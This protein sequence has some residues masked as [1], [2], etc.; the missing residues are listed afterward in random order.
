M[1]D[2]GIN[3]NLIIVQGDGKLNDGNLT[4]GVGLSEPGETSLD[5][6]SQS[7]VGSVNE[8]NAKVG[9]GT[10]HGA[11]TFAQME[12]I[13]SPLVGD[14]CEVTDISW[15]RKIFE[16]TG[17]ANDEGWQVSGETKS[18]LCATDRGNVVANEVLTYYYTGAVSSVDDYKCNWANTVGSEYFAGVAL[19]NVSNGSWVQVADKGAW[20][21]QTNNAVYAGIAL[22]TSLVDGKLEFAGVGDFIAAHAAKYYGSSQTAA[23]VWLCPRY[24]LG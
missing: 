6:T 4:S 16:Y 19:K 2:V 18:V 14:T 13:S 21:V 17:S 7:L 20:Y 10:T 24:F 12:A 5:T 11:K 3:D 9:G 1:P 22:T 23:E 8:V 15:V